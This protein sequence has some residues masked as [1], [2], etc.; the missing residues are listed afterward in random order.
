LWMRFREAQHM[1]RR[2][3]FAKQLCVG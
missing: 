3:R 2:I 1:H